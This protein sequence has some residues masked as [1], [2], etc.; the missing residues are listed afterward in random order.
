MTKL[1]FPVS[2]VNAGYYKT[3]C[4]H[5]RLNFEMV[6]ADIVLDKELNY[7][8]GAIF[9]IKVND[10]LFFRRKFNRVKYIIYHFIFE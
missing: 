8:A 6:N 3:Y 2:K 9:F 5:I 7:F 4:Y 1:S 10:K